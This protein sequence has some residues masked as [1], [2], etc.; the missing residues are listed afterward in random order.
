MRGYGKRQPHVHSA[1]VMLHRCIQ[2]L[3]HLGKR[4]DLVEGGL[5]LGAFHA[6]DGSVEKDIFAT[7]QFRMKAGSNFKQTGDAS[8]NADQSAGRLADSTQNFQ[9]GRFASSIAPNDADGVARFDSEIHI[10]QGPT[11]L[12]GVRG[13]FVEKPSHRGF[14]PSRDN[15]TQGCVSLSL[16]MAEDELL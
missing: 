7:G 11:F 2:E 8:A 6:E 5:Y 9:K 12:L 4:D 13:M 10:L 16:L 1:R 15:V 3:F 14:G